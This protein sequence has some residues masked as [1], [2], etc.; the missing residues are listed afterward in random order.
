MAEGITVVKVECTG[1]GSW[2]VEFSA[3][4]V[5]PHAGHDFQPG[6]FWVVCSDDDPF[7]YLETDALG[8]FTWGLKLIEKNKELTNG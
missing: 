1:D 8:A 4:V 3:P 6:S 7:V 5:L 2:G